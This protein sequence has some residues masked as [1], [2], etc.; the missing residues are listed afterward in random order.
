MAT[1]EEGVAEDSFLTFVPSNQDC[2]EAA[3]VGLACA[4]L[5]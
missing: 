2:R 4:S 3:G 1:A 5:T